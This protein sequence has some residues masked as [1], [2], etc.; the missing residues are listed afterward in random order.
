MCSMLVLVSNNI[1]IVQLTKPVSE[2]KTF[3][4]TKTPLYC[5]ESCEYDLSPLYSVCR[6][7]DCLSLNS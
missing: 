3:K 5:F 4:Q 7:K 1:L 6:C 2:E